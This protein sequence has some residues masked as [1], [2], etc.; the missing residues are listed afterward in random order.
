MSHF[1][2]LICNKLLVLFSF[3][4]Q[5]LKVCFPV[6]LLSCSAVVKERAYLSLVRS[7]CEAPSPGVHISQ[8]SQSIKIGIDTNRLQSSDF[9][10]LITEMGENR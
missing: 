7:V 9:Y 8:S 5:P 4:F 2:I 6:L 3:S 10:R 1:Q